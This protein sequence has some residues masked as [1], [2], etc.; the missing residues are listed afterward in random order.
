[1]VSTSANGYKISFLDVDGQE[2]TRQFDSVTESQQAKYLYNDLMSTIKNE[3]GD[4]LSTDEKR[5][6]L[7]NVLKNLD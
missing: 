1:M 6:V 5:Q 3:Y 4:S 2:I 7:F